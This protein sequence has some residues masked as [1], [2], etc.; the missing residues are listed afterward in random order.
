M[1]LYLHQKYPDNLEIAIWKVTETEDEL[2]EKLLENEKIEFGE[3]VHPKKRLEYLGARNL[4]ACVAQNT[5]FSYE[6]ISKDET[7]KPF[8][9]E[10]TIEISISHCLPWVGVVLH[11]VKSVGIDIERPQEKLEKVAPRVFSESEIHFSK[12]NLDLI[13]KIWCTKEVLY[14]IYAQGG[15]TFKTDFLVEN[16]KEDDVSFQASIVMQ[17][18]QKNYKIHTFTL[19]KDVWVCFGKESE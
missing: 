7:G 3:F 14:K 12:N 15:N 1:P 9:I 5:G 10:N 18:F 11:P 4:L 16:F 2:Y 6:G 17:D 8:L 19:E 13:T